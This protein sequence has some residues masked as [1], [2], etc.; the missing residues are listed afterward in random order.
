M[1]E[2][3]GFKEGLPTRGGKWAGYGESL[4]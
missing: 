1:Q 4:T 3:P 2:P